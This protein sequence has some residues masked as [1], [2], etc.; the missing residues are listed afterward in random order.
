[1][2]ILLLRVQMRARREQAFWFSPLLEVLGLVSLDLQ[3]DQLVPNLS[4]TVF[5]FVFLL[6]QNNLINCDMTQR[7]LTCLTGVQGGAA[8]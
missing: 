2:N 6:R 1:M 3:S 8:L 4:E 5:C 7:C